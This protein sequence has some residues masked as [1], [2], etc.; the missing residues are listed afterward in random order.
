MNDRDMRYSRQILLD[1]IALDGQQNARQPG[2]DYR[3]GRA[4]TLLRCTGGRWRRTLVLADDDDVHLSNL[5]RQILFTTE[6][7][8][9]PKSQVSQQRLTQL[10]PDIQLTALQQRLTGEAR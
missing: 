3:S 8:D 2:A 9:R 4:G 5:Q 10:N 7:I 6:D 1:D